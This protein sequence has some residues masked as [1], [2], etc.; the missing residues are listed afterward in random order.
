MEQISPM[1]P[2]EKMLNY[3]ITSLTDDELLALL[4]TGTPGNGFHLAQELLQRFGSLY[5]LLT[6]DLAEFKHV[7]GLAWRNMPS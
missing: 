5:G 6:A 3:G 4:R 1:L 2:R 7:E